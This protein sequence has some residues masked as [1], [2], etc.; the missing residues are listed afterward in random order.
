[1]T[2]CEACG[3][4]ASRSNMARHRLRPEHNAAVA[5][6]GMD[7]SIRPS[8]PAP[9]T[10]A[11]FVEAFWS[12]VDR[13]GGPR[14]C[15]PWTASRQPDGYGK[16]NR[17]GRYLVASHVALEIALGRDLAPGEFSCHRCDNPPCCNPAHLFPGT[18]AENLRDLSA[19]GGFVGRPR[20]GLGRWQDPL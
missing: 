7:P 12:K 1:M 18:N 16:V 14:A 9:M 15:W 2:T 8:G 17:R 4:P 10:D 11:E 19:K 20:D 3:M 13:S 5:V 6:L